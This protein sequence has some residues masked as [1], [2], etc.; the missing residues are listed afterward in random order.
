MKEHLGKYLEIK[1]IETIMA[2]TVK[3]VI[4]ALDGLRQKKNQE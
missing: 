2:E 4:P 1:K 3:L